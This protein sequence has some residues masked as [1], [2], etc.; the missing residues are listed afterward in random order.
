V[1]LV[2]AVLLGAV[3][4]LASFTTT[5]LGD[6]AN[7]YCVDWRCSDPSAALRALADLR[8]A[9]FFHVQPVMGLTSLLLRAPAV[10]VANAV[11]DGSN[12]EQYRAGA[13]VCLAAALVI[14]I[15]VAREINRDGTR[16]TTMWAFLALWAIGV[17]WSRALFFGHPEEALGAALVVVAVMLAYRRQPVA[18]GLALALAI[19]TKEWALL[20]APAVA[21]AAAPA[22]LRRLVVAAA[23]GVA[24]LLGT[25]A[26]GSPSSFHAAHVATERGDK[27]NMTPASIWFRSGPKVP[28][29][30][31]PPGVQGYAVHPPHLVGRWI[32]TV[33][34]LLALLTAPLYLR[35]HGF[36]SRE[37]LALV[38]FLFAAR[39]VLDT[40][41]YSY[42]LAPLLLVLCAW[43]AVGRKRLPVVTATV[44]V[45]FQLTTHVV[46]PHTAPNTFNAIYLAWTLPLCAYLGVV[47]FRGRGGALSGAAP[48]AGR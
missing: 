32:R 9:E 36:G 28:V 27:H 38:G 42:H 11:G 17:I 6:Y 39:I 10:A 47:V 35:R 43:E 25:M 44:M 30:N 29:R 2:V 22:D 14:G 31:L 5:N 16:A 26:I 7:P 13:F 12:L 23:A 33:I 20:A 15:W 40:Q 46:A 24:V 8:I 19:A 45:A 3:A 37:T 4:A 1:W 34:L 21:M 41:T 48:A 18:A